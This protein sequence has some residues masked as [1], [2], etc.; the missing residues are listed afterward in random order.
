M[1]KTMCS[2]EGK[3]TSHT[4]YV[5]DT[6]ACSCNIITE[7]IINPKT[8]TPITSTEEASNKYSIE[9]EIKARNGSGAQSNTRASSATG[10]TQT[11]LILQ[12]SC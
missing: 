3:S 7:T 9:T 8:V 1:Y 5:A 2:C 12:C 10:D 6:S 11:E 4:T